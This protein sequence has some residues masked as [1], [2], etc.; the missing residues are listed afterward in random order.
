MDRKDKIQTIRDLSAGK[1]LDPITLQ[2][3]E[4]DNGND[5]LIV[6]N[7]TPDQIKFIESGTVETKQD[8]SKL[9]DKMLN[10]LVEGYQPKVY[11]KNTGIS[12][13]NN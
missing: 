9:S 8:L 13:T 4:A 2:Y 1:M 7:F 10:R 12:R 5:L 11:F 3:I 6:G